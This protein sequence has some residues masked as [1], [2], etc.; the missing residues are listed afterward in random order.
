M[1]IELKIDY[2]NTVF[3]IPSPS[4]SASISKSISASQSP[5]A[6]IYPLQGAA[7][8]FKLN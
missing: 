3:S 1:A 6:P 2:W 7:G 5:S 8:N 4:I